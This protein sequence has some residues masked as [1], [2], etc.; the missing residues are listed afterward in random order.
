MMLPPEQQ[1]II[2]FLAQQSEARRP[3]VSEAMLTYRLN[4][5]RETVR[6][7]M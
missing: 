2:R 1:R 7:H 6:L 5:Q 4:M 3:E